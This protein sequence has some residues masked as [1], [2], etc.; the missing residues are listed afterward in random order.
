MGATVNVKPSVSLNAQ[1]FTLVLGGDVEIMIMRGHFS[2]ICLPSL[3]KK[4]M[5][6][7]QYFSH[8]TAAE[9]SCTANK[10]VSRR[11]STLHHREVFGFCFVWGFFSAPRHLLN[12]FCS[13][14]EEK[15]K[16]SSPRL[17]HVQFKLK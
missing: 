9:A 10:E 2:F 8:C 5:H 14:R 1:D 12:Q 17:D 11:A 7:R 6:S 15:K 16:K 4:K 3:K 13:Q